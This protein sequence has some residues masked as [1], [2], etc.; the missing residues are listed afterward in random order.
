MKGRIPA[1]L[2][3]AALLVGATTAWAAFTQEGGPYTTGPAPYVAYTADFNRDG[4]PD[5]ATNNGD[6]RTFSVFLRQAGGGFVQEAGS[7]FP[8]ASSNGAIGDFNGDGYLDFASAGFIGE[9]VAVLIRN[10]AGGFTNET[11]PALGGVLSAIG[12][13]DF[14]GDG[15][16]DMA[17]ANWNA[18]QV[19]ILLRNAQN[20]GFTPSSNPNNATGPNP[21]QIAVADYNGDGRLDLAVVNNNNNG[22]GTVTILAGNGDGTFGAEGAPVAVG[23]AP[24]GI[25]AGDFNRDGRNDLAVTNAADG[26][27]TVLLRNAGNDGFTAGMGSPLAIGASPGQI[28]TADFNRD[29][30]LDLAAASG[31]GLDVLLNN[32]GASFTRDTPTPVPN[33]PSGIATADFNND[34]VPDA[35][36]S[37]FDGNRTV[38][39]VA[40]FLSPS[41][42]APPPPT[43]T[44]TPSPTPTPTPVRNKSVAGEVESGKVLIKVNGKFVPLGSRIIANGSEIDAR[45]GRIGITTSTNEQADFYDGMFK[46]SQT[47]GL[48]TLTLSEKLTGCPKAKKSS[49]TAAAKKPKTRKLW[50][51]GKGKFRTK[52][53]YS[54]ATIRGTKWLVTDTCT[55]TV[56][57][58]AAGAV[59]VRDNVKRKTV[60]VRKGKHYTARKKR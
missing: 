48:T 58:V 11:P 41:P 53:Q 21:R 36:V 54:A 45:K 50:G 35:A 2:G 13:G 18:S 5:L 9:G 12:T 52:G 19:T 8:S 44:A 14:N 47:G 1:A 16:A 17:V 46:I 37:S 57:T 15:H 25:V 28:A 10:P 51:D 56:T 24:S 55:T 7:P 23:T 29:G 49:A 39:Q 60:I 38:N 32:G 20:T 27:V 4:L 33:I 34:G 6:G 59:D 30:A 22:A 31:S 40:V 43:P 26:T 42:P 3:A